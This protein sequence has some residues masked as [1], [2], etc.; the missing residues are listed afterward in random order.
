MSDCTIRYRWDDD[1]VW[2]EQHKVMTLTPDEY[3]LRIETIRSALI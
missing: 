2:A 3:W 1:P